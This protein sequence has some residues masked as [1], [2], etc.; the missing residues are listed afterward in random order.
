MPPAWRRCS[1][2]RSSAPA[3]RAGAVGSRPAGRGRVED[4]VRRLVLVRLQPRPD[5][6]RHVAFGVIG[7]PPAWVAARRRRA[8]RA[9]RASRNEV[10]NGPSRPGLRG[11]RRPVRGAGR[12]SGEGPPPFDGHESRRK[13][14]S[15]SSRSTIESDHP[16]SRLVRRQEPQIR[17]PATLLPTLGVAGT[18]EESVRPRIEAIRVAELRE[19]SPGQQRLLRRV[20]GEVEVAQDPARHGQEPIGDPGGKDGDASLSPAELGSRDRYPS[21]FR[22]NGIGSV[23]CSHGMG[24]PTSWELQSS[25]DRP[26]RIG[27]PRG[28]ARWSRVP[29]HSG[30]QGSPSQFGDHAAVT[31]TVGT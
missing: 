4:S 8:P 20:L 15:S 14:R 23:R 9:T 31:G 22:M 18:N 27:R 6:A 17:C 24:F 28:S 13:P 3:T 5:D 29:G 25:V 19:V 2:R 1:C 12:G 30:E 21:P 11:S 10:G 16:P 26:F 7:Q